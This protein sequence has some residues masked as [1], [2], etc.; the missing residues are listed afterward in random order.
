MIRKLLLPIIL[1]TS[2]CN[3][4][5][6][7][8]FLCCC[9]R[10]NNE[11]FT[12][13][14]ILIGEGKN[15]RDITKLW[16]DIVIDD[17]TITILQDMHRYSINLFKHINEDLV[18]DLFDYL[19]TL[20]WPKRIKLVEIFCEIATAVHMHV[21]SLNPWESYVQH[22]DTLQLFTYLSKNIKINEER[23]KIL[24]LYTRLISNVTRNGVYPGKTFP[25]DLSKYFDLYKD[26]FEQIAGLTNAADNI[27]ASNMQNSDIGGIEDNTDPKITG[28]DNESPDT[29]NA[30]PSS[31]SESLSLSN[32][33]GEY[34]MQLIQI[35]SLSDNNV[36]V[37]ENNEQEKKVEGVGEHLGVW[38]TTYLMMTKAQDQS[39]KEEMQNLQ[40]R[41]I[42]IPQLD[43]DREKFF[44]KHEQLPIQNE[45]LNE[46]LKNIIRMLLS[47]CF[48]DNNVMGKYLNVLSDIL[49]QIN[50]RH[51]KRL[52][53]VLKQ[54]PINIIDEQLSD[55]QDLTPRPR[56]T[57][58]TAQMR[59]KSMQSIAGT[60]EN[61]SFILNIINQLLHD[62]YSEHQKDFFNKINDIIEKTDDTTRSKLLYILQKIL[63]EIHK[64]QKVDLTQITLVPD[65]TI[66]ETCIVD[67]INIQEMAKNMFHNVP[68]HH[69][70]LIL[71]YLNQ[72]AD[73]GDEEVQRHMI[74]ILAETIYSTTPNEIDIFADLKYE[75]KCSVA[76][77]IH[78]L[79]SKMGPEVQQNIINVMQHLIPP[80]RM[81]I[82]HALLDVL[83]N[84]QT[85][86]INYLSI[87]IYIFSKIVDMASIPLLNSLVQICIDQLNIL[88]NRCVQDDDTTAQK[89]ERGAFI[90]ATSDGMSM[91][92]VDKVNFSQDTVTLE[93]ASYYKLKWYEIL[94]RRFSW[95]RFPFKIVKVL[96]SLAETAANLAPVIFVI[97][98]ISNNK[99]IEALNDW[100]N[101]NLPLDDGN[102]TESDNV[103]NTTNT[104]NTTDIS[105]IQR[106]QQSGNSEYVVPCD[107]APSMLRGNNNVFFMDGSLNN[108]NKCAIYN[109][110]NTAM[111]KTGWI[112]DLCTKLK[113]IFSNNTDISIVNPIFDNTNSVNRS[114]LS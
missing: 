17:A 96:G 75:D 95:L 100:L 112:Y 13:D 83:Y 63:F 27:E 62:H 86:A 76:Y 59:R 81:A 34:S 90:Q 25:I 29:D 108:N 91:Y 39:A 106:I 28:T 47:Q 54:I 4:C 73:E 37:S 14:A 57:I 74:Q 20:Q 2:S 82:T 45:A 30:D 78:R 56:N 65:N 22:A 66:T 23:A 16:E 18:A 15:Q 109:C 60:P 114:L 102:T 105:N 1:F 77:L 69:K 10:S 11:D 9:C 33:S 50:N 64:E 8:K 12:Q 87:F 94:I 89:Y 99:S 48:L 35:E 52:L 46:K 97:V 72:C 42:Q 49:L 79:N 58:T 61:S 88:L 36:Q 98:A 7:S 70:A 26:Y 67:D 38:G 107:V 21:I 103:T 111:Y 68:E 80:Y 85:E 51:K 110:N 44:R 31:D 24:Q 5:T 93:V 3:C 104:T 19:M 43:Y 32:E 71:Q 40:E 41:S 55:S 92:G 53:D 6:L 84:G 101:I 113:N